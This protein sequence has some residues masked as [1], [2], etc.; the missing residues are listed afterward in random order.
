MI[1]AADRRRRGL[2]ARPLFRNSVISPSSWW[3]PVIVQANV[4]SL[5]DAFFPNARYMPQSFFVTKQKL[6]PTDR[7]S[8][9]LHNAS[10]T[11]VSFILQTATGNRCRCW[12]RFHVEILI[13]SFLAF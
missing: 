11:A 13:R 9:R 1:D 7:C 8:I 10:Q 4:N 3:Y 12:E 2:T 5:P 6:V